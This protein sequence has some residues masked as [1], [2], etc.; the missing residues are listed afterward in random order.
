MTQSDRANTLNN[1]RKYI[2]HNQFESAKA[3][4]FNTLTSEIDEF[5]EVNRC[6]NTEGVCFAHY[7]SIETLYSLIGSYPDKLQN[8]DKHSII[9][10]GLR[11]YDA[12]YLNDPKEGKF[13][14]KGKTIKS[15]FKK[16]GVPPDETNSFICSFVRGEDDVGDKLEYWQSYGKGG[17]GCSIQLSEYY[18]HK[19]HLECVFY[20]KSKIKELENELGEIIELAN[21]FYDKLNNTGKEKFATDYWKCFDKVK[22]LFK[23]NDYKYENESRLVKVIEDTSEVKFDFKKDGSYLRRYYFD[24]RLETSKLLISGTRIFIGPAVRKAKHLCA[25]LKEFATKKGFAGPEFI[26]S[27]IP[28][29][30]FW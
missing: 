10:E 1:I 27:N 20:G 30:K 23:S 2:D 4:L 22:F 12:F 29:Q 15:I 25:N 3:Q 6:K 5:L 21:I 28:Y 16:N 9:R 24:Q 13:L 7:T 8:S 17:L 11:L 14:A 19:N 26:S 18:E